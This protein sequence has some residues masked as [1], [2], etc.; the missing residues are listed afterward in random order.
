MAGCMGV[1][2]RRQALMDGVVMCSFLAERT[3][4]MSVDAFFVGEVQAK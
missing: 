2:Q 4:D 1:G 3:Q